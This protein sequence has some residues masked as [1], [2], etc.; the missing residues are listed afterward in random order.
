MEQSLEQY[1]ERARAIAGPPSD[2]LS[3]LSQ[4]HNETSSLL[5]VR[6]AGVTGMDGAGVAVLVG[7]VLVGGLTEADA[8][9]DGGVVSPAP[10]VGRPFLGRIE[11]HP[12]NG[13]A[14]LE[15]GTS[16]EGRCFEQIQVLASFQ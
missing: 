3:H 9:D 7:V 12:T 5:G 14:P 16:I 13:H 2:P 8:E 6:D 10:D 11:S 4:L 15:D 1:L